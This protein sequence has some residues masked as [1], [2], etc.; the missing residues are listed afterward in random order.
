MKSRKFLGYINMA[1]QLLQNKKKI[2]ML[3]II[4]YHGNF[5]IYML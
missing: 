1:C 3:G 4:I 5:F 2:G